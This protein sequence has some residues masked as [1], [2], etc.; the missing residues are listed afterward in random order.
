M[1]IL[2]AQS[3]V[4][5]G[6]VGNSSAV[7]PLQRLGAEVWP[8]DTVQFSNHPGYGAHAGTITPPEV[9]RALIDGIAARGALHECDA[10][11]SGYI[12][13]PGTGGALLHAASRLRAS[14][15]RAVW[16][17][18]PVIGDDGP[19]VYVRPGVEAFLRE[20]AVPQADMLTPN[21][22]ELSRLTGL[23]CR[24]LAEVKRAAAALHGRMRSWGPRAVM[25]TS[26]RLDDTPEDSLDLFAATPE[27]C[28][29]LRTP[30]LP[31]QTNGAGD[32][33]A[34]LFLFHMLRTGEVGRAMA[35]AASSVHG[36]LS[37]TL[38]AR[39]RELLIVAAQDQFL[40]PDRH[41]AAEPC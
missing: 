40:K 41:F 17:C 23:P 14:N 28:H 24:S 26:L 36:V 7:F 18:D 8:I 34:G 1:N 9:I 20:Q 27:D 13:D 25:V 33:I 10:L 32:A 16:C 5:F 31:I 21:Q 15:G 39:S 22:F 19:G 11:L 3:A 4:V 2:S 6:H 29:R 12:G 35:L 30:R 38:A 37:H